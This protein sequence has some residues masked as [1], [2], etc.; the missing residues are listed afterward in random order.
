LYVHEV[1]YGAL[2]SAEMAH[3]IVQDKFCAWME[4]MYKLQCAMDPDY[5]CMWIRGRIYVFRTVRNNSQAITEQGQK[6]IVSRSR[7][8]KNFELIHILIYDGK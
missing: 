2:K 5:V 4:L 8:V 3:E 1:V 6:P 7:T